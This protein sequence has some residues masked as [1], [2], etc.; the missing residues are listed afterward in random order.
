MRLAPPLLLLLVASL[1]GCA[2]NYAVPG[3]P[4]QMAALGAAKV[5][6]T[7]N[8][9]PALREYY[10]AKPLANFPAMI[11]T[12]RVQSA[13]YESRTASAY[14]G[15]RYGGN[16]SVITTRDVES[17]DAIARLAKLPMVASIAPLN[18]LLLSSTLRGDR[19]LRAAAAR[20]KAD[21]LVLYTFDTQF[22]VKDFAS[23]VTVV[24]LGLSPNKRAYVTT[25][26][27]AVLLDVRSGYVYGGAEATA[28]SEQL[29]SGWT[30]DD[31]VDDTRVRTERDSFDK[32]VAELG[33]TW[34]GVVATYAAAPTTRP[35]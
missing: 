1:A 19:D 35:E 21:V 22:Y 2:A 31:A 25:T 24:T 3:G 30:S 13:K 20:L 29:A 34:A 27:T 33:K 9:D 12:A 14:G 26:A 18:R 5:D 11:A 6:Q 4:A 23:P 8:T 28:R 7:V 17:D 16:F 15:D 32:L 10:D